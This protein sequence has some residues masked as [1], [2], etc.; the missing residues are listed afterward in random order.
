MALIPIFFTFDENYVLPAAVT[1]D[2]LLRHAN[3]AHRYALHVLHLG[4]S[5]RAQRELERVVARYPHAQLQL[6]HMREVEQR[7]EQCKG[8]A[9]FSKEIYFKLCAAELFP[10][11]ERILCS[12]V[13]VIFQDDISESYFTFPDEH[14]YI[15]GVDTILPTTRMQLYQG[16][17]S[18]EEYFLAR[19]ICAGYLLF[20]LSSM[21]RDGIQQR[22]TDYYEQHYARLPFPEQDTMAIVCRD[23][24][25]LLSL[26]YVVCNIYYRTNPRTVQFYDLCATLPAGD[27]ERRR[28]YAD[29][30][31]RPIQL[32]YIGPNK[33]W[34]AL[35][36]PRQWAWMVALWQSR[37]TG[38]FLS[39]LPAI[40]ARR[41]QRYSLQRFLS[42]VFERG[43]KRGPRE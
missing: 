5:S 8:K 11:Y 34:N 35:G 38:Y 12:D 28:D 13:D 37:C 30:L 2:S 10:K 7:L 26:R 41:L 21:R 29:A 4:L 14:F 33:P 36:V 15:A 20:N 6:H 39:V 19:Q 25:R 1:F 17:T 27:E 18:E 43:E 40:V 9:H 42:R 22:L 16:F 3:R 31:A 24:I 32:H 23:Q